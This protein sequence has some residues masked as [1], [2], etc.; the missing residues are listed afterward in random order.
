MKKTIIIKKTEEYEISMAKY[1]K[2]F[3]ENVGEFAECD[4]EEI[5]DFFEEWDNDAFIQNSIYP[6]YQTYIEIVKGEK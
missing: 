5:K 1:Q 2:I 4:T 6:D 3:Y